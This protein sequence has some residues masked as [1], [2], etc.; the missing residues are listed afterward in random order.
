MAFTQNDGQ[1]CS[2]EG[3]RNRDLVRAACMHLTGLRSHMKEVNERGQENERSTSSNGV[4]IRPWDS[5]ETRKKG[6]LKEAGNHPGRRE[7]GRCRGHPGQ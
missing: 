5:K 4:V 2:L 6:Y 1:L 3:I 7:G